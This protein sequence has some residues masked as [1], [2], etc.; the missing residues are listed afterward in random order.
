MSR[1]TRAIP[2]AVIA[3]LVAGLA[4]CEAGPADSLSEGAFPGDAGTR[5]D[6][7]PE[8]D[9]AEVQHASDEDE[10]LQLHIG[11]DE[12]ELRL[13]ERWADAN[14][15]AVYFLDRDDGLW[16]DDAQLLPADPEVGA[17]GQGCEVVAA[18]EHATYYG[19]FLDTLTVAVDDGDF[20]GDV[21]FARGVGPID[22]TLDQQRWTA[23]YY[24]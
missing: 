10:P 18:G 17:T 2:R 3:G 4:A 8:A 14:F 24:E 15:V 22:F 13:G 19:T 9:G 16:V 1:I 5:I 6:Y 12:W 21:V 7:L 23:A 11:E 20:A